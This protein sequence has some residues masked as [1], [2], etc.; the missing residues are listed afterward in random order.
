MIRLM[1]GLKDKSAF[2]LYLWD[3]C[4][5]LGLATL[6][7]SKYLKAYYRQTEETVISP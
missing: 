6:Q 7:L 3:L 4:S 1:A 2:N 5:Y